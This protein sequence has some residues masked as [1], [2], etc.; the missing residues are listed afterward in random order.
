MNGKNIVIVGGN[1]GIGKSV[2]GLLRESGANL[3]L[4]SK[5]GEGTEP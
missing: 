5:S 1:S 3:F 2:A 4:Y